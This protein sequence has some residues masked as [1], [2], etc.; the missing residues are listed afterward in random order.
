MKATQSKNSTVTNTM[1]LVINALV[2]A[3]YIALC[4]VGP[5][6]GPIQFRIAESLNHLVVFNKKLIWGVL[7]GVVI[8]NQFFGYGGLDTLFGGGQTLIALG[9]SALLQDKIKNVKVR[10]ALNVFVFTVTMFM[11]AILLQLT[12]G[13]PFW[14]TYGTLALS[15]FI[16]MALSAPVM[17]FVDSKLH[18]QN[19]L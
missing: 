3:L 16:I 10:L 5:A 2:A 15:E 6:S 9:I 12:A 18:F 17:L 4:F 19:R 13:A 11:I 1:T 8:F 14:A 7:L